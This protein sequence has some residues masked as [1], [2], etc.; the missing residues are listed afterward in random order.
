MQGFQRLHALKCHPFWFKAIWFGVKTVEIRLDDRGF[1]A[2]DMLLLS[3]YDPESCLYSGRVI[4][5]PCLNVFRDSFLQDGYVLM[6]LSMSSRVKSGDDY[7][8]KQRE[9]FFEEWAPTGTG[10]AIA[11]GGSSEQ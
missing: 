10:T 9:E 7:S 1:S 2:G 11:E 3:E 4:M 5:V 6:P 8:M